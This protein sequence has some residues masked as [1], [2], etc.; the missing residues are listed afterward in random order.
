MSLHRAA[1]FPETWNPLGPLPAHC[2]YRLNRQHWAAGGCMGV[3]L[4]GRGVPQN[5]VTGE[6]ATVG[7]G[8]PESTVGPLG[9]SYTNAGAARNGW[10]VRNGPILAGRSVW[11]VAAVCMAPTS[12]TGSANGRPIYCERAAA[13]GNDI[14]KLSRADGSRH[15]VTF[16]YRNTAGNLSNPGTAVNDMRTGRAFVAAA[17]MA[18]GGASGASGRLITSY[19]NGVANFAADYGTNSTAQTNSNVATIG[20]DARDT[21]ASTTWFGDLSLIAVFGEGWSDAQHAAF[22]RAPFHLLIPAA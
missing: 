18:P 12:S 14:F 19:Y 4:L 3:W 13:A 16:T 2:R 6:V 8:S 22:A 20:Y 7:V 15:D 9:P 5:L 1:R 11:T 21:G 17:S 10:Q